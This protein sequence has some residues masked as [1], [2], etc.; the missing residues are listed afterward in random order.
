MEITAPLPASGSYTVLLTPGTSASG[1]VKVTSYDFSDLTG[2]ITPAATAEGTT[3]KVALTVP[4]QNA[5]Y[6]VTMAA[7]ERVSLRTNNA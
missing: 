3:Q 7:G 4:G 1:S 5:R 6:S 2:S